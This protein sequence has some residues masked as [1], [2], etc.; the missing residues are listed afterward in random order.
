MPTPLA[1]RLQIKPGM[2]VLLAHATEGFAGLLEPLPDGVTIETTATAP[3][4]DAVVV[5]VSSIA[6]AEAHTA[7]AGQHVAPG[8]LFWAC[9]PKK[10]GSIRTDITRD[11]GWS[12]L[13]AAG[14]GPV[15]Q[16]SVNDTWSALRWRPEAEI[17]RKDGS[18]F[19]AST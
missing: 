7:V 14:W 2:R 17:K 9:Y 5:C 13:M 18:H 4:Y 3:A 19:K 10:S 15:Q 1:Q 12:T 11:R 16:V 6:E 8:G